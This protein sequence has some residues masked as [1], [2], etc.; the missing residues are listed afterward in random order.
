MAEATAAEA[1]RAMGGWVIGDGATRWSGAAID[2]RKVTGGEIFFAL[3]GSR[4]DG[5][6]FLAAAAARGARVGV[7]ERDLTAP[8]GMTLVRVTSSYEGLH[9]LTRAVRARLPEKLVAITG[10]TGKTTTKELLAAMLARRYRV[11]PSQGNLNNLFGFPVSLLNVPEGTQWMVAEMGMSTPGEL[12]EISRLGRPDVALFTNVR[13]VHLENFPDLRGIADA[14]AELLEGLAENGVV[15][16]NAD[17]PWVMRIAQSCSG[18][19][20]RYGF[21]TGS[22]VR[23]TRPLPLEDG[24]VGSRFELHAAGRQAIV[25]LPIHGLYNAENCLAAA[26]CAQTLG[27]DLGEIAAAVAGF[28]PGRQR[29]VVHRLAGG[30]TLIDDSYNSNPIAAA[31]ALESA[32]LL[33][34]AR[35]L[36]VLGDMLELGPEAPSFHRR[37]GERASEL[38]FAHVV[39]VG[40]LAEALADAARSRTTQADV[41]PDAATAAARLL[42][43]VRD[44]DL[45]LVKGS[46]GIGLETVVAALVAARGKEEGA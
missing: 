24:R 6:D 29:G 12:G 45:V 27:V 34:A 35:Y 36:A 26:A 33:P 5:H 19:V 28:V 40:E 21:G 17:D 38:G 41:C 46:R 30:V 31:K 23:A 32:V 3:A 7:V 44:G 16:V 25:E 43:E 15:I 10:S 2:S 42:A 39:G 20:V 13:P 8:L 18:R 1:A 22:D 11:A 4:V 14:K 37:V 9:A